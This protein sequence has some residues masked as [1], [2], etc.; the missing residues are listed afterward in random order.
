MRFFK[1][2]AAVFIMLSNSEVFA[3][4]KPPGGGGGGGGDKV[5]LSD[6]GCGPDEVARVN[7][8]DEWE[9][10]ADLTAAEAAVIN[11]Q[12][13]ADTAITN[14][15]TAQ[16]TANSAASGAAAAQSTADGAESDIALIWS[17]IEYPNSAIVANEGGDYSDVRLAMLDLDSWCGTPGP[18]NPC[19]VKV[20]P[21]YYDTFVGFSAFEYVTVEGSGKD[22][23]IMTTTN[24]FGMQRNSAI[25]DMTLVSTSGFGVSANNTF[26]VVS[27]QDVDIVINNSTSA[28]S[29]AT[30][31]AA[32]NTTLKLARVN[33]EL[34]SISPTTWGINVEPSGA[35]GY[36]EA[37]LSAEDVQV[38][39]F[40]ESAGSVTGIRLFN[41]SEASLSR[42]E[43]TAGANS[44][45][46]FLNK[47]VE[48]KETQSYSP[49]GKLLVDGGKFVVGNAQNCR[50]LELQSVSYSRIDGADILVED[51]CTGIG[52]NDSGILVAGS[53]TM[54]NFITNSNITADTPI[55]NGAPAAITAVT[56]T[57][58]VGAG[59]F[60]FGVLN[61]AAVFDGE[62][63]P[64]NA[65]CQ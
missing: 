64:L 55:N 4:G 52:F 9:C 12:N 50:G 40:S 34:V 15:A 33:V 61:C 41:I 16:S 39:V 29:R 25:R 23:T 7:A 26:G 27:L 5:Q 49:P 42:V 14:A 1:V 60:N 43:V 19:L 6:L 18:E 53:N 31:I 35:T 56:S 63:A 36:L 10:S 37:V 13:T 47:G 54:K 51:T 57:R 22:V 45:A 21:G 24:V 28:S 17:K 20:M 48:F 58:L 65:N 30:G 2:V 62:M 8:A 11:A 46:P 3:Q 59:S 44:S 38:S 32:R